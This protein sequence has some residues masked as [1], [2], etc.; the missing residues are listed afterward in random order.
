[1]NSTADY[2]RTQIPFTPRVFV[3][4]GS[5]LGALADEVEDAITL[6]FSDVPG[7]MPSTVEGHKGRLV[8]GTLARTPVLFM[9]GRMHMYEGHSAEAVAA[10]VRAAAALGVKTM[11]ATN[12][13]GGVNRSFRPGDLML[14][15][16][17]I[18]LMWQNPLTGAARDGE[19]RFPDM[20][21]PYDRELQAL[22]QQIA[23]EL[24]L[25]LQVGTYVALT[26]PS[27]E[28]P[29]EIRMLQRMGADAIGMSTVP[30]VI[31][32]RA[33]DMRVLGF[34]LITNLAAGYTSKPLSHEEVMEV[35]AQAS[36]RV[37]VLIRR[38][39]ATL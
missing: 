7:L 3:I 30:E 21:Q 20:S 10:P 11:I 23:I 17:H 12:S 27:Y 32:A 28:T 8:A 1:M 39:I 16:D 19:P 5:G 2:L 9:Q 6:P 24:G 26:G 18:N 36:E 13:A 35:G 34:S 15:D 29:A 38:V 4:L 33:N 25:Q 31:A 14:I 37:G 22:A